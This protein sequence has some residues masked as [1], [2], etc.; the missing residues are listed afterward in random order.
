[1]QFD[2]LRSP[3][4]KHTQSTQFMLYCTNHHHMQSE[5]SAWRAVMRD[6]F[7]AVILFSIVVIPPSA[8]A[9]EPSKTPLDNR[10]QP[11]LSVDDIA[12]QINQDQK[13]RILAAEPTVDN[14]KTLYRFKLLN[15]KH[16]RVKVIVIDPNEPK[17]N[18]LK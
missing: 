8:N 16:G 5:A 14:A 18:T 3:H 9:I 1:M 10:L 13:W 11:Q 15:K 17:L 12:R 4:I 7:A 6:I 2:I